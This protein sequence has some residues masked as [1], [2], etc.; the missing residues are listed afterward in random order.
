M[1]NL[2]SNVIDV[3]GDGGGGDCGLVIIEF[4]WDGDF[5]VLC[6]IDDGSGIFEELWGKV[7]EFFFIIKGSVGMGLGLFVVYDIV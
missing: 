4:G 6:V 7:F 1:I 2:I 3:F 5:G